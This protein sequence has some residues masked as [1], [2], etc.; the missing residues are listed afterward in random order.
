DAQSGTAGTY[1]YAYA[2]NGN[3]RGLTKASDG[4]LA[5]QYEYG[6]FGETIRASG[7]LAKANPFR[8]STKFQDDESDFFCYPYRFYTASN[9]RWLS[10]DPVREEGAFLLRNPSIQFSDTFPSSPGRAPIRLGKQGF[11]SKDS[12][13]YSF[14]ENNPIDSIDGLG[15]MSVQEI[16]AI[17][18]RR[19]AKAADAKCSCHCKPENID[20][21][22]SGASL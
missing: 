2:G 9:G 4:S 20:F 19:K 6:A 10:Q 13:A 21:N 3:L 22:I 5:A 8:F 18:S 17:I 12:L 11:D 1:F 16:N 7:L 14:N 15:L